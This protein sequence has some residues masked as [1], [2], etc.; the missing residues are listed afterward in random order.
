ML[1]GLTHRRPGV[2]AAALQN[3]PDPLLKAAVT[4][5]GVLSEHPHIS[6]A[7]APIPLEDLDGRRFSGAVGAEQAEHL[8]A[9]DREGD[10]A[11]GVDT[12]VGL[13][14]VADLDRGHPIRG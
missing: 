9:L 2:E 3:D 6:A 10:S 14:Q 11:H 7:A 4:L 8:A 1:H 5:L 12:P 13:A